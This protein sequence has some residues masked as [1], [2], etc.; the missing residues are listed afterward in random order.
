MML[1]VH[2]ESVPDPVADDAEQ[3]QGGQEGVE[4]QEVL[5][6][7][8]EGAGVAQLDDLVAV[9]DQTG[10]RQRRRGVCTN[11]DAEKKSGKWGTLFVNKQRSIWEQVC[12]FGV[13]VGLVYFKHKYKSKRKNK[14]T[15]KTKGEREKS[16]GLKTTNKGSKV[17]ALK[18]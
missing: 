3:Q 11:R 14:E 16:T 17:C 12:V 18:L 6:V 4:Q 5:R 10:S 15:I 9:G 13:F 7:P 8:G 1:S 2:D